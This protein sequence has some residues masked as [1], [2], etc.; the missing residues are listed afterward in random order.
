ME[1][2]NKFLREVYI[3]KHN[4]RYAVEPAGS[5]DVHKPLLPEHDLDAI[6]SIQKDRQVHNDSLVRFD[7]RF[8]LLAH[9]HGLRPKTKVVVEQ[10]LD[11]TLRIAHK[12]RYLE[13]KEVAQRP[14]VPQ[15][16]RRSKPKAAVPR[17][18]P[19]RLPPNPFYAF[20][21]FRLRS[22]EPTNPPASAA[23]A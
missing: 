6:L 20:A 19:A 23:L 11:G 5:V 9:G 7:S 16:Q 2:A 15:Q 21:N 18:A 3:P 12:G 13:F 17:A 14:H 1:A 10:R 4:R 22:S 8:F